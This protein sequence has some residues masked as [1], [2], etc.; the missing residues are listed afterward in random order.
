MAGGREVSIEHLNLCVSKNGRWRRSAMAAT[1]DEA[2]KRVYGGLGLVTAPADL[3]TSSTISNNA[4]PHVGHIMGLR[5][6]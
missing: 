4:G 6:G 3:F 1:Y 5:T 2:E